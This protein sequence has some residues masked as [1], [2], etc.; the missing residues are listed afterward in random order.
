[1]LDHRSV[2]ICCV[3]GARFRGKSVTMISGKAVEYKLFCIGNEKGL[4]GVWIFL[5]KKWVDK[6][7][8]VSRVSGRMVV[9]KVLVQGI[10]IPVISVYALHCG[11][12]HSKKDNLIDSLIDFVRKFGERETVVIAEDVNVHFW[13]NAKGC[14]NQLGGYV[15]GVS[16]EEGTC[17]GLQRGWSK[18]I[19][20]L[21]LS[22]A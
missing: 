18:L 9:V 1:M 5:A 8:D 2:G 22:S 11:L 20:I 19:K 4:K 15:Y 12:D 7:T 17:L 3:K 21:L 16:N 13:S 10:I 6:V 14:E